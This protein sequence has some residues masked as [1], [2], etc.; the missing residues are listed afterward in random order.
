MTERLF[1]YDRSAPS[2]PPLGDAAA[3]ERAIGHS[4]GGTQ[5]AILAAAT[6][7]SSRS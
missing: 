6:R 7:G 5:G 3:G 2:F 1:H 4:A